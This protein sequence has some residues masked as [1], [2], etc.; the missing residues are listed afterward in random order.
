[1]ES[2]GPNP[3]GHGPRSEIKRTVWLRSDETTSTRTMRSGW[4]VDV[5]VVCEDHW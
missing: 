2:D 4:L 1:M 5:I 3:H